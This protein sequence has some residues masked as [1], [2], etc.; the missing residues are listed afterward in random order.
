[1]ERFEPRFDEEKVMA[2]RIW[3]PSPVLAKGSSLCAPKRL[4]ETSSR[5]LVA[6]LLY[7]IKPTKIIL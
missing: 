1:M 4:G 7:A 5:H 6:L 3:S 2:P